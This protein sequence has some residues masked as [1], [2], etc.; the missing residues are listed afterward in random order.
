MEG[1]VP[2]LGVPGTVGV[3]VAEDDVAL[4]AVEPG[5]VHGGVARREHVV[6]GIRDDR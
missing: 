4:A 5:A 1:V 3:R 6:A 2:R